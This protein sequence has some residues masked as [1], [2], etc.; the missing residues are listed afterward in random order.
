MNETPPP[1]SS[2]SDPN[3]P[4][5]NVRL[6]AARM[7]WW[8]AVVNFGAALVRLFDHHSRGEWW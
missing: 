1:T 6:R 7:Q 5:D 3:R 8:A 2:N 4:N